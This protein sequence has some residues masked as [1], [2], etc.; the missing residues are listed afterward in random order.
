MCL[1]W[2]ERERRE[3]KEWENK[4]LWKS[5]ELIRK[6]DFSAKFPSYFLRHDFSSS[7]CSR[8]LQYACFTSVIL[9]AYQHHHQQTTMAVTRIMPRSSNINERKKAQN[10][11][12]R[13]I[14]WLKFRRIKATRITAMSVSCENHRNLSLTVSYC[15]GQR[16]SCC[17][18]SFN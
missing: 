18:R 11:Q 7:P 12:R 3:K 1:W 13:R 14:W 16:T 9:S 6:R 15:H 8:R 17:R 10:I 2:L 5:T 4:H